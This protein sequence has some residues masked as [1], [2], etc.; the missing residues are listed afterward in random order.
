MVV[1]Y[2]Q[3]L[4]VDRSCC[5]GIFPSCGEGFP[6][7]D[8]SLVVVLICSALRRIKLF[9]IIHSSYVTST[10]RLRH[11]QQ[12]HETRIYDN[13]S[14]SRTTSP[15]FATPGTLFVT[16][17]SPLYDETRRVGEKFMGTMLVVHEGPCGY[18]SS[19]INRH[20]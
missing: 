7:S 12:I 1:G 6:C 8:L 4:T 11:A 17:C 14:L 19:G 15:V 20:E 9:F 3:Q 18:A 5:L 13:L 10:D 2:D 16:S